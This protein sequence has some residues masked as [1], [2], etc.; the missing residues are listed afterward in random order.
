[1]ACYGVGN[2]DSTPSE[3]SHFFVKRSHQLHLLNGDLGVKW[4]ESESAEVKDAW[5]YIF[6]PAYAFMTCCLIKYMDNF[7]L[8]TY[9]W[10]RL[11]R[12]Y[13]W[14]CWWRS[15]TANMIWTQMITTMMTKDD[16]SNDKNSSPPKK[17][18]DNLAGLCHITELQKTAIVKR[19]KRPLQ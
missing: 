1:V 15:I 18:T 19:T 17:H 9:V 12:L 11:Q 10:W 14:H 13:K 5:N 8:L 6:T 2:L 7:A 16:I 4:L 3:D